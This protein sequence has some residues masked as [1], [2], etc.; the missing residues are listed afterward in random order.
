MEN[1]TQVQALG[2]EKEQGQD[3]KVFSNAQKNGKM[4]ESNKN[5]TS[6]IQV[7][8]TIFIYLIYFA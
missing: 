7:N 4:V 2:K 6:M 3:Q 1:S 5:M 8:F